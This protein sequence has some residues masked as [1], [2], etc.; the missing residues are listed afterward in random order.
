M[1]Y[2]S[3]SHGPIDGWVHHFAIFYDYDDVD[4]ILMINVIAHQ[5]EMWNGHAVI[6][7]STSSRPPYRQAHPPS[8]WKFQSAMEACEGS[9]RKPLYSPP[10][11]LIGAGSVEVEAGSA[12]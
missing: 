12:W 1:R 4:Q 6:A 9:W 8:L 5:T 2:S 3:F 7:G 11:S 10:S